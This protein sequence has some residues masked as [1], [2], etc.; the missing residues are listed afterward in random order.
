MDF[1]NRRL[2]LS[3]SYGGNAGADGPYVDGRSVLTR[4]LFYNRRLRRLGQDKPTAVSRWQYFVRR[5][6]PSQSVSAIAVDPNASRIVY[7]GT[8]RE[9]YGPYS[10]WPLPVTRRRAKPWRQTPWAT[11]TFAGNVRE[12]NCYR[13]ERLGARELSTML[14]VAKHP[15]GC[16]ARLTVA[17]LFTQKRQG[18]IYDVAIDCLHLPSTLYVTDGTGTFKSTDSGNSWIS[19][20]QVPSTTRTI[21]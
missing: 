6:G 11:I 15:P 3:T 21:G 7:A 16:G 2:P 18:G 20:H 10:G 5:R 9:D 1:A 4:I 14:Y 17:R 13:S 12:G 8:G 19:I